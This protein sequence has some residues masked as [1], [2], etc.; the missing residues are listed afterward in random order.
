MNFWVPQEG[1]PAAQAHLDRSIPAIT[2]CNT[3]SYSYAIVVWRQVVS[4]YIHVPSLLVM[5]ILIINIHDFST[6][7]NHP[8][9]EIKTKNLGIPDVSRIFPD[10]SQNCIS[11]LNL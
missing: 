3:C 4:S 6:Y 10:G 8:D 5:I 2:S 9:R 1:D 11:H 7:L